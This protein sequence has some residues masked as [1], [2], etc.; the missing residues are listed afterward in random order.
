[1]SVGKWQYVYGINM[2]H[3]ISC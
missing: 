2:K 1:M 3:L